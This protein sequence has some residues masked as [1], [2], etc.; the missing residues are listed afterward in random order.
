VIG[1]YTLQS[2]QSYCAND[3]LMN[4]SNS[5]C[6]ATTYFLA[7]LYIGAGGGGTVC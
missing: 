5:T 1:T 2:L 3:Q 4:G 6:L 7:V